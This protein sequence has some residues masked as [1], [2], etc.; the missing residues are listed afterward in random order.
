MSLFAT[1]FFSSTLLSKYSSTILYIALIHSLSLL[2]G[3]SLYVNLPPCLLSV[4]G[5]LGSFQ[6]SFAIINSSAMNTLYRSLGAL[7]SLLSLVQYFKKLF[8]LLRTI[9]NKFYIMRL[10]TLSDVYICNK[11]SWGKKPH[12]MLLCF[13]KNKNANQ[14]PLS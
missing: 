5:H 14:D 6:F 7:A 1:S 12:V 3:V 11:V 9:R 2:P 4:D 13:I 10:N 8:L